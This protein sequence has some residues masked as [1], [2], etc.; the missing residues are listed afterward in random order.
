MEFF[1][2]IGE[3]DPEQVP[4]LSL[5]PSEYK[6]AADIFYPFIKMSDDFIPKKNEDTTLNYPTNEEILNFG[7]CLY[8]EEIREMGGFDTIANVSKAAIGEFTLCRGREIYRRPDLVKQLEDCLNENIFSPLSDEF[9]LLLMNNIL[10]VLTSKGAQKI[11]YST[12]HGEEGIYKIEDL[13]RE[14]VIPLCKGPI[15]I[16]D[17]DE[18]FVFTCYFDDLSA[19]FLAKE[20]SRE[21]LEK[22]KLEGIIFDK[23][24]PLVWEDHNYF[25]FK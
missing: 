23:K 9:P 25:F 4:L 1:Y 12:I 7:S 19:L 14:T 21:L 13:N 2:P 10:S 22:N 5:I 3:E 17:I 16:T 18:E 20:N 24:T 6:F 8:W 15:L 11:Q